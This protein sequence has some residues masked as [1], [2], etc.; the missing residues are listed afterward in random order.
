MPTRCS[1][2]VI[3]CSNISR[4][5]VQYLGGKS[6]L[7]R[8]LAAAINPCRRG[9]RVVWDAFC[10][11]LSMSAELCKR[12]PVITSDA[13]L[14]LISLYRAVAAGWDPPAMV[15]ED[16]Y[17]RGRVLPDTDPMKAFLGFGCSFGGK[18]FGGY[19][20]SK[21]PKDGRSKRGYAS[22]ARNGLL[23]DVGALVAAGGVIVH[24]NFLEIDP[25]DPEVADDARDLVLYLDPPYA[26]TT[27][28]DGVA[29]F[30]HAR[31]WSRVRQWA[32]LTD[33]FVSEYRA[34]FG[35]PVLEFAHDLSVAGGVT[36]NAR[37]ERLYHY[38]PDRPA[39]WERRCQS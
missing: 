36:K 7:S 35:R 23:E 19:A 29:A 22:Q 34:P 5:P 9:E 15:T 10:G 16:E 32:A 12:G 6:R 4:I 8:W 27:G 33:V 2:A 30:D 20:R 24:C 14:A 39:E 38:A 17:K 25:A 26:G 37:R 11:G 31:F 1:S 13:N 21:D 18:W 3:E 28:Y